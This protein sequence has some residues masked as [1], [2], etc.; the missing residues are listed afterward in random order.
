MGER[1]QKSEAK[2]KQSELLIFLGISLFLM[3]LL[4]GT[5]IPFSS[6]P[7]MVLSAHLQGLFNGMFLILLGLI[8]QKMEL[9]YRWFS[10]CF[11]FVLYASFANFFN[12]VFSL[13]TGE[14]S[15]LPLIGGNPG[16]ISLIAATS[17]LIF[18][19]TAA[20]IISCVIILFGLAKGFSQNRQSEV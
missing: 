9:Q 6:E 14:G 13:V 7:R 17:F 10:L 5:F 11:V 2:K 16:D 12:V 8:W 19:L 20:S 1:L 3:G 15:K 4:T 18:T